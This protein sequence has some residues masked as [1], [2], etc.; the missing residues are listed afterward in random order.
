MA[1]SPPRAPRS[2]THRADLMPFDSRGM[3]Y[4]G[5]EV[6]SSAPKWHCPDLLRYEQIGAADGPR[7]YV[8]RA[9]FWL[10]RAWPPRRAR[11]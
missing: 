8:V 6:Q 1:R 2:D 7:G 5:Y 10:M 3:L 4:T 9:F 11:G